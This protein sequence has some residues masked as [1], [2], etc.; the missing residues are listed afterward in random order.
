VFGIV[1]SKPSGNLARDL[2]TLTS[3]RGRFSTESLIDRDGHWAIA[4]A[5]LGILQPD[6]QL[7]SEAS[8]HALFHGDLYNEA[9]LESLV[10]GKPRPAGANRAAWL[11]AALYERFGTGFPRHLDGAYCVAVVDPARHRVMLATDTL[12]S[13]PVYWT[14]TDAGLVFGSE[15]RAVLPLVGRRPLNAAAVADYLTFG[16]PLGVK[17]L[18]QG[19]DL[20]PPGSAVVFDWKRRSVEVQRWAD[21]SEAFGEWS[22][23]ESDYVDAVQQAFVDAVNRALSGA[24]RFALSLSGGLDSRAILSAVNGASTSLRTCTL[25]VRGCADEAIARQLAGVAGTQHTFFEVGDKYLDGFLLNL[26]RMTVLTDGMYLSH[27]L[28][29]MPALQFLQR[30]GIEVLLRGHGGELAKMRRAW[31]LHTD[32]TIDGF[33]HSAQLIDYLFDRANY[34]SR[35]VDWRDLFTEPWLDELRGRARASLEE[36]VRGISLRPSDLCSYLYLGEHHRRFT[37]SSLEIF[38]QTVEVRLPFVD[39]VFLRVLLQGQPRWRQGTRLHQ[40]VIRTG[41]PALLRIRDSNTGAPVDAGPLTGAVLDKL[42]SLLRRLNVPGCRHYHNLEQWMREQLLTSVQTVLLD[43][44]SLERGMLRE[45]GLRHL[46]GD[47]QRG[48][49]D[50]SHLLQVLLILELWQREQES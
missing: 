26:R 32:P 30:A 13:Y 12:G 38:R 39:P 33:T 27:G 50:Q 15:L 35:R 24:H 21:S 1:R 6:D 48:G 8:V 17:T 5:H 16:F 14:R 41:Q 9:D 20:V 11:T 31:P 43:R 3:N 23:S 49:T 19:V 2:D 37:V 22:G 10:G 36:S 42:N 4:R 47:M 28:T 18:A 34:I 7:H 40:A 45:H 44:V 29:E 25:G 46:L